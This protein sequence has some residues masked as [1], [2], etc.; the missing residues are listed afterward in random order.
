[1]I[2]GIVARKIPLGDGKGESLS[3]RLVASAAANAQSSTFISSVCV[4]CSTVE[5][6]RLRDSSTSENFEDSLVLVVLRDKEAVR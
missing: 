6:L 2:S 1:M 3:G 5:L 4:D